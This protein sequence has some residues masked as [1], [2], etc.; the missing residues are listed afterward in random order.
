MSDNGGTSFVHDA[1]DMLSLIVQVMNSSTG[2]EARTTITLTVGG[3]V[4][5]GDLIPTWVWF[6]E[7]KALLSGA[8]GESAGSVASFFGSIGDDVLGDL[9]VREAVGE[10]VDDDDEDAALARPTH[11]HLARAEVLGRD[12]LDTE[13]GGGLWRG[14]LSQVSGWSFGRVAPS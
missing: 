14:R 8:E 12:H 6:R 7:V 11:L 5:A 2:P 4:I 1:D 9:L 3:L 10:H 13:L